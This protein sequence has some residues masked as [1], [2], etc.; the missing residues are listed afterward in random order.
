MGNYN[1]HS[2]VA[3]EVMKY[4]SIKCFLK[5]TIKELITILRMYKEYDTVYIL[6]YDTVHHWRYSFEQI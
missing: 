1:R 5:Q 6:I 2:I 3:V 4:H